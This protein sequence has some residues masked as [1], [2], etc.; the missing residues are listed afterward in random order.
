MT[1]RWSPAHL[2]LHRLLRQQPRLLPQQQ[3]LL[4]AV[5]GGQDSMALIA[6]LLDL[7]RLHGWPLQLW[8]G[9][10]GWREDSARH[11]QELA[12]WADRQGLALTVE[13][14]QESRVRAE[15]PARDWRYGCLIRRARQL[16]IAR[17]VSGHTASDRAETLLLNLARGC[18]RRGLASLSLQRELAP[19]LVL[20]RPLLAFSRTDTAAICQQW[21][22]PVWEDGSNADPRFSR[23]R[24]R[25]EVIPVLEALHPGAARRLAA[26]AERLA[27]EH[28]SEAGL[29]ALALQP[30]QLDIDA[31]GCAGLR[32]PELA[33][34]AVANQA[35]LLQ[36]W[37]SSRRGVGLSA[38]Q[39]ESLVQRLTGG[40][41]PGSMDLADGW[42]LRWDRF[43]VVLRQTAQ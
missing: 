17:V 16:G 5:S 7:S 21:S 8:H 37:V 35:R 39:L 9:D 31:V 20:V 43:K 25:H 15:A 22:L 33:A 36:H 24:V 26:T 42:Q 6:L 10:H 3:P 13:R 34:Q 11:A 29:L 30:L 2:R 14:W 1:H 27:A 19:G 41:P 40:A 23:N 18:H 28:H 32:R 4:V 38:R 12:A